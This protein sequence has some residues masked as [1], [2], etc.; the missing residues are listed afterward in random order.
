MSVLREQVLVLVLVLVLGL[1][2][3]GINSSTHGRQRIYEFRKGQDGSVKLLANGQDVTVTGDQC[4][5][6]TDGGKHE[7]DDVVRIANFG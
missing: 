2:L 4:V 1:V 3:M 5:G 6:L 7:E